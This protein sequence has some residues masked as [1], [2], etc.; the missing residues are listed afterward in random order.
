[1]A[2]FRSEFFIRSV[3]SNFMRKKPFWLNGW[4]KNSI[5]ISPHSQIDQIKMTWGIHCISYQVRYTSFFAVGCCLLPMEKLVIAVLLSEEKKHF[6][7]SLIP[8]WE[9]RDERIACI[10]DLL[11]KLDK[12][13]YIIIF[14]FDEII[15]NP[16]SWFM[17]HAFMHTLTQILSSFFWYDTPYDVCLEHWWFMVFHFPQ[18][19]KLNVTIRCNFWLKIA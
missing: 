15:H 1:M 2:K 11:M 17:L 14:P 5:S 4:Q 3:L 19:V 12:S 13:R 6:K 18:K 8:K 10:F 16:H 7:L 9:L